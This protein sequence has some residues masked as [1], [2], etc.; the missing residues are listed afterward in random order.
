MSYSIIITPAALQDLREI[1]DWYFEQ[2][3]GLDADFDLAFAESARKIA[4]YPSAGSPIPRRNVRY[5]LLQKFPYKVFYRVN[6]PQ[7][8]IEIVALI[9]AA[10]H[11]RVWKRRF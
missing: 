6:E 5:A 7:K 11:P 9:H 1:T 4:V 10:R 3:P 8:R 2:S